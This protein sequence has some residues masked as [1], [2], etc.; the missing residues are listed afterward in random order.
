M[1]VQRQAAFLQWRRRKRNA[2]EGWPSPSIRGPE[3]VQ[4]SQHSLPADLIILGLLV[5]LERN[6]RGSDATE[7]QQNDN[8]KKN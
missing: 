2:V 3:L 7:N 4:C 6:T 1:S 8:D 5:A